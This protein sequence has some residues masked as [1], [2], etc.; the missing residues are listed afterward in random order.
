MLI[1]R[2]VFI[3]PAFYTDAMNYLL[4][5]K[6]GK[7]NNALLFTVELQQKFLLIHSA[8]QKVTVDSDHYFH[9]SS[10][11]KILSK[12]NK[13]SSGC[14]V[15]YWY[16]CESGRGDHWWLLSCFFCFPTC[17]FQFNSAWNLA[18]PIS[19]TSTEK[20]VSFSSSLI[21]L[22]DTT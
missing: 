16:D 7:E 11:F 20:K 5:P 6:V 10:F 17:H 4:F 2:P 3:L 14:N 19:H 15:S 9:T 8:D 21:Y 18:A 12:E 13:I 1:G 22:P